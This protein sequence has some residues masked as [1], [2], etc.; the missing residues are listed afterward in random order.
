MSSVDI[1]VVL[2]E[3]V[4]DEN[5]IYSRSSNYFFYIESRLKIILI[6]KR[7]FCILTLHR[8]ISN[9]QCLGEEI[10]FNLRTIPYIQY[11]VQI[12]GA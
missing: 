7:G 8:T 3:P 6:R 4:F 11:S 10:L 12:Y 5:S 1:N 9:H 2:K